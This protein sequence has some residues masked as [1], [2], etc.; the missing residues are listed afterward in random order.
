M[1]N[2]TLEDS[3]ECVR[4]HRTLPLTDFVRS[5]LHEGGYRNYCRACN[6]LYFREHYDKNK[7]KIQARNEAY[8]LTH[9]ARRNLTTR[10]YYYKTPLEVRQA[11]H[12]A[13][14]AVRAGKITPE[15]CAKCGDSKT[16]FH[17]SNGYDEAN[18]F[19][20][21]WLCRPHHA[22]THKKVRDLE[23]RRHLNEVT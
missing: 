7:A 12:A 16:D 20:G 1:T 17:H 19:I 18:W 3:R 8:R 23:A 13:S 21:E 5:K 6:A 4:C 14:N 22:Q 2:H 9:K 10:T 11:R 15:P